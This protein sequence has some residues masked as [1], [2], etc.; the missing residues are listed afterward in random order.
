MTNLYNILLR[1]RLKVAIFAAVAVVGVVAFA[2]LTPRQYRSEAKLL[3][4]LGRENVALDPTSTFGQGPVLAVPNSREEEINSVIEVLRSRVLIDKVVDAIGADVVLGDAPMDESSDAGNKLGQDSMERYQAVLAVEKRLEVEAPKKSNII[5]ISYT[6]SDPALAQKIIDA[7]IDGFLEHHARLNR[8]PQAYSFLSGQTDRMHSELFDL[9]QELAA[10]KKATGVYDVVKQR[11]ILVLRIGKIEDTLLDTRAE[12]QAAEQQI[13]DLKTSLTELP[14][15]QVTARLKGSNPAADSMRAQL[16][17]LQIKELELLAKHPARHP[18]VQ[19]VR[20][21]AS[22][23]KKILDSEN[24]KRE[25]ITIGP[26]KL[27]EE[28]H[29]LLLK[30][31]PLFESLRAK[32]T[33]LEQQLATEESKLKKLEESGLKLTKLKRQIDIQDKNFRKYAET[34]EQAQIDQALRAEK[35]SNIGIVQPASYEM[36]PIGPR[37]HLIVAM[38]LV[39]IV[40]GSLGVAVFFDNME[41]GWPTTD[42][43]QDSAQMPRTNPTSLHEV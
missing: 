27:Y 24:Q 15:T 41:H 25:Q 6:A 13:K 22:E 39:L 20:K 1:Q 3:V 29:V 11:E 36:K 12:M 40:F 26:N 38:G 4:R 33:S 16:F 35:I 10:I 43:Q 30:L 32:A 7:L 28:A 21:Q 8:T 17:D 2:L 37:L 19:L 42:S 14:A 31:K 18:A 34:V 5:Q 23:A 9:E